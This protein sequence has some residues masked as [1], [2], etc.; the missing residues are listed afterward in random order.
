MN[1]QIYKLNEVQQETLKYFDGDELATNVWIEKYCLKDNE[2]NLLEKSPDDTVKRLS[3]EFARIE[4]NKF[5]KPLTEDEI[6]G[7]LD[8]FKYIVPAG[9]P[10]FGIGNEYQFVSLSNCY[11]AEPPLDSYTSILKT[12]AQ[13]I[14]ISK[15]RGGVGIDISNLRPKG[16]YTHNAA[17]T[18]TGI[19]PFMERY[20][21]SIREVGQNNRRGALIITLNVHHPEIENFITIKNDR[22]KVTGANISI[23]LTNEFLEAVKNNKEYELRWPVNSD[24][25]KISKMVNA[26]EIWDKIIKNAWENAEPGLLFWD[27][28]TTETPADCYEE[29][30]S[31]GC[32]P[33][34]ELNLSVLDSCRLMSIN[35]YSYVKNQFTKESKFDYE[36]FNDHVKIAQR[37]M[38]DLV[39]LESEKIN[40][41]LAKIEN[42]PE[43]IDVKRDEFEMWK[44]IKKNNDEGRRTGLG[45]LGLADTFAALGIEYGSDESIKKAEKISKALKL[46]AYRSSVDMAKELGSFKVYDF[47]KEKNHP[48]INRIKNEDEELYLDMKKYGRRNVSLIT[49]PPTGSI[50]IIAKVSSGLEP[51]FE[52]GYTRR[53]KLTDSN[54]KESQV[55]FIDQNGDKW[56]EYKVFHPVVN[57]WMKITG[58]TD[59]KKSPWF[60]C[61]ANDIDW[62]N[63]VKLQGK[64][65]KNICH[66]ISSTINLPKNVSIE[67][68]KNIYE[69]AWKHGL[70]GI[71][72]YREGSR[73]GVLINKTEQEQ[74]K[75][76]ENADKRPKELPCE[77][78][79]TNITKKLDKVRHFQ[80][81]VLIGILNN[82]PYE[83]FAIEN[84][85]FDKKITK[86][87]IIKHA[88]GNYELVLEDGTTVKNITVDTTENEDSLTRLVS[89]SLRH[90]IPI[91][92]VVEQLNKVEG[93]MFCFAKS[94]SR[95]LKK[96]IK[97]GTVSSEYCEKCNSKLVF[98]NGCFICKQCGWSKC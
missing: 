10:L 83:I 33:C 79:H 94:I 36:M 11:L 5:K 31:Q 96:F 82:K 45:F 77:I 80:Y 89:I 35:L 38:D 66:S 40:A 57:E 17:K 93:E 78:Y 29:F 95:S 4:K 69:N 58:E 59:I 53:R 15:R 19:I 98:E 6:Y 27:N 22:K 64:I 92:Y 16:E 56:H 30:A 46:S 55:D 51:L 75:V 50:S 34:S 68:V 70:K 61:C 76:N 87:K 3:K 60:G 90:N 24:K 71:T 47:N 23:K 1:K 9:S 28:I 52:I 25:P 63:R 48:F 18:T 37:L 86:G 65:Q 13:L 8:H 21:N 85:K 32:N 14:Y 54:I 73:S 44:T 81:M 91:Q 84:G 2:D 62:E 74:N 7:Y 39:D 41:I 88:R 20:S 12:D 49:A 72:V 26:K 43:P 42:D 97:D 67:T